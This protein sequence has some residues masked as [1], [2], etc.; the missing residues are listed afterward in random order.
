MQPAGPDETAVEV[1]SK[2]QRGLR[3]FGLR[4]IGR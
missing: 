2:I 3:E 4:F 1:G